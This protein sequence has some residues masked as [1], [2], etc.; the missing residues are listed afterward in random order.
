MDIFLLLA[1]NIFPLYI[2]ITLGYIA[3]RKMDVNLHSMAI[4]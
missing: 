4:L 1:A 3:G 2:L